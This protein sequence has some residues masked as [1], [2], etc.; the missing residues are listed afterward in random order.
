MVEV[1]I[2]KDTYHTYMMMP[3]NNGTEIEDEERMMSNQQSELL[4]PFHVQQM[5]GEKGYYYDITGKIDF[6]NYIE[7]QQADTEIITCMIRMLVK[8]CHVVDEYLLNLDSLLLDEN[9]LYVDADTKN[10]YAA[11]VP[12]MQ[13]G[14]AGQ[15]LQLSVCLLENANH[16]EK[17]GVLLVYD[18]YKTVRRE[19]FTPGLL[20]GLLKQEV[21]K[22]IVDPK[23]AEIQY[24]E[25]EVT[26]IDESD[27]QKADK[28]EPP[29]VKKSPF[30]QIGL[31]IVSAIMLLLYRMGYTEMI[32]KTA[33]LHMDAGYVTLGILLVILAV[34]ILIS[35]FGKKIELPFKLNKKEGDVW[36]DAEFENG[37]IYSLT[38]ESLPEKTIILSGMKSC[39]RL[40]SLNKNVAEDIV[41]TQFPCMVGSRK[42]DVQIVVAA[43]GISRQHVLFE[44]TEEGI[45]VT[46]LHST[47]GTRINGEMLEANEKRKLLVEDIL[48]LADVRYMYCGGETGY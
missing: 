41:I 24:D 22:E 10:V 45:L 29:G 46:D 38:D 37:G 4:L 6:R 42:N 28:D 12:G 27:N 5:N 16:E 36:N 32:L 47:N 7:K 9:H 33:G 48:E 35:Q 15:L 30:L 25:V 3:G 11:Y 20:S 8:L 19:D 23:A 39:V 17:E 1:S 21:I 13:G 43:A 40:I 2:C 14:F 31:I 18:F 34:V 26:N 44:K